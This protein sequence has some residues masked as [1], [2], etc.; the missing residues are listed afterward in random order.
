M[1]VFVA[2]VLLTGM[3]SSD[4]AGEDTKRLFC[5]F[6]FG[7][8]GR[9]AGFKSCGDIAIDVSDHGAEGCKCTYKSSNNNDIC[10][11]LKSESRYAFAAFATFASE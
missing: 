11:S 8:D 10:G 9:S 2:K 5:K 6:G 7:E 3:R 1:V 4:Q